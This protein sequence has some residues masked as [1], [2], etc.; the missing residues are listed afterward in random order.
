MTFK[1]DDLIIL[2]SEGKKIL[3]KHN[4]PLKVHR[5]LK[6]INPI[7]TSSLVLWTHDALNDAVEFPVSRKYYRLATEVEFKAYKLKNLFEHRGLE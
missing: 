6:I 1:K 3:K 7:I 4:D 5:V 2:N